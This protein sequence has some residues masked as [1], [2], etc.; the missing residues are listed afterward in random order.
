MDRRAGQPGERDVA[1]DHD[2]LRG[3]GHARDAEPA[4]PAPLVHGAAGG[5]A[6]VLAVLGEGD[7]EALGVV[8]GAPH[9]RAVLDAGAVVGEEHH[10]Q[11]GQ[12]AERGERG[13]GPAPR[14]MA[15][16]TATSA[17]QPAP[18]ASTSLATPA[19]SIAGSVFGMATT[20]V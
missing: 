1:G 13:A 10:P 7:A 9:E 3:G 11:R 5:Q 15:P 2:L 19:E 16:A 6:G 18:S 17:A 4:R 12:L 20:A 8:E 14:V